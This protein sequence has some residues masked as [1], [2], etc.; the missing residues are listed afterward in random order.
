MLR[1]SLGPLWALSLSAQPALRL[2]DIQLIGSHN[3]YHLGLAPSEAVLL[4]ISNPRAAA[5]LDYRH[6]ALNLQLD[7]GA[8]QFEFDIFADS[9]GGL[10]AKS[11]PPAS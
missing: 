5:A 1:L 6:P 4:L 2:T 8:R 10:F 9:Q 7:R 3:S 11:I